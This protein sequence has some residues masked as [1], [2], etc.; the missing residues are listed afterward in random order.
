MNKLIF[1]FG[2]FIAS[3]I[4][5]ASP[6]KISVRTSEKPVTNGWADTGSLSYSSENIIIINDATFSSAGRKLNA[7]KN[8][9]A[10]GSV[11]SST[12][13][14]KPA[15]IILSG[16]VDLSGG[17]VSDSDHSYFD[18]FDSVS[19]A[20]KHGDFMY[21]IGS[22]KTI[23]G[24]NNAK[25]AF[26]GLRIRAKE[27]FKARNIIIRNINF[28]DAHGSTEYDTKVEKYMDKKAS[29]DQ[30]V[31][32]GS[33]DKSTKASYLYIPEDIWI[34]HCTFSDGT[35]VD[36]DRNFNHDG[37]L[38]IKCGKNITVSFCEFTNH[39]KVSL[40]GSSDK[41]TKPEE[42]E[43]TFHDNYYHG[44]VQRMPRTRAGYFH[45]YNNVFDNIGTKN[46]SGASLGPGVGAQFIVEN[47]FFGKHAGKILRASDRSKSSEATFYKIYAAG[48]KP[49]LGAGNTEGFTS[50]K[51]TEKPW[52]PLYQYS[53]KTAD[54][55]K[56]S[57]V[58]E[59]GSGA[60]VE[61]D[62]AEY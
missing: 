7:F 26:G 38:D 45:L 36:L 11:T 61:I 56:N 34:D 29:A 42:R 58:N 53:L 2:I 43:V 50:H 51:V 5:F 20:R 25:V 23:I 55:T 14:D 52:S 40:I 17:K 28:W 60:A 46:N 44:C 24:V 32:E 4:A 18:E 41:F 33:E 13:N 19:H 49:E 6:S 1:L 37:A 48:N 54:E 8:A 59:A 10:S 35:C 3:S 9:V 16:T 12:V 57:V 39:D 27:D 62:G 15:L 47:N 21:D 22:N 31:I 30:L